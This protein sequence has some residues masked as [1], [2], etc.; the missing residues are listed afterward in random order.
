M[1]TAK[2][3]HN[4]VLVILSTSYLGGNIW[5]NPQLQVYKL[6]VMAMPV[7]WQR[8]QNFLALWPRILVLQ[9]LK[10]VFT[11]KPRWRDQCYV[12][13]RFTGCNVANNR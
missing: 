7:V 6:L 10:L 3:Y 8:E 13:T 4:S 5:A 2:M 9:H 1:Y 11:T 12:T